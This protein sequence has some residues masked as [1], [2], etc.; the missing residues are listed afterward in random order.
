MEL[1]PFVVVAVNTS[2][3]IEDGEFENYVIGEDGAW[4]LTILQ[5]SGI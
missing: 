4:T 2:Q 3:V 5:L 1:I